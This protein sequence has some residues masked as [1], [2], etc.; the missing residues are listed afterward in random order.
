[1]AGEEHPAPSLELGCAGEGRGSRA[2]QSLP[3]HGVPCSDLGACPGGCRIASQNLGLAPF[4]PCSIPSA[5]Q[6]ALDHTPAPAAGAGL[7]VG[8]RTLPSAKLSKITS[9]FRTHCTPVACFGR[10]TH[11][12]TCRC[13]RGSLEPT[14]S[15]WQTR[16]LGAWVCSQPQARRE[17]KSASRW[18]WSELP[19]AGCPQRGRAGARRLWGIG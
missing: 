8:E 4:L 15:G 19:C 12:S 2:R 10:R 5:S 9:H 17:G 13:S 3:R 6:T 11:K 7:P 16:F 18:R 1:M 14:A